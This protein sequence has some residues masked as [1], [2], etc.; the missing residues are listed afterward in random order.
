MKKQFDIQAQTNQ[1]LAALILALLIL[2]GFMASAQPARLVSVQIE[3]PQ[4]IPASICIEADTMETSEGRTATTAT[5]AWDITEN[6]I[7]FTENGRETIFEA[8]VRVYRTDMGEVVLFSED[9]AFFTA[10]IHGQ[11]FGLTPDFGWQGKVR[12]TKK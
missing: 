3:H 6:K 2:T 4:A 10:D 11:W 5:L 9:G 1:S 7:R 8:R 12:F